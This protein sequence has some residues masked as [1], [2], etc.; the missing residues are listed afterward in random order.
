M[1]EVTYNVEG[2][3]NLQHLHVKISDKGF[4]TKGSALQYAQISDT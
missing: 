3:N 2:N 1:I 4:F